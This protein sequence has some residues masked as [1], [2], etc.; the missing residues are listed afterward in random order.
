L[1]N[2]SGAAEKRAPQG[3][4]VFSSEERMRKPLTKSIKQLLYSY[5]ETQP[6]TGVLLSRFMTGFSVFGFGT[7][8]SGAVS[9]FDGGVSSNAG[10][11]FPVLT[12]LGN[13]ELLLNLQRSFFPSFIAGT[14][15]A[16]R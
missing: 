16:T 4:K 8:T 3:Q 1:L 11:T 7:G 6:E 13:I 14:A 9:V 5:E 12:I 2:K 15:K 10:E